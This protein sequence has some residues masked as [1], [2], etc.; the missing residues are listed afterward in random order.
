MG[1]PVCFDRNLWMKACEDIGAKDNS[2]QNRDE[3]RAYYDSTRDI[4]C[5][6][7]GYRLVRIMH[8]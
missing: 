8:G 2:P 4:E 3:I 6:K 5:Y 7:H 1:V